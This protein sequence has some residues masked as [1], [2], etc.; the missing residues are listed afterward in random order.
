MYNLFSECLPNG[1]T[2]EG[3]C[4]NDLSAVA[5]KV[6][7]SLSIALVVKGGLAIITFGIKLP[8][9]I[10]IPTLGV[11][12]CFGRIMGIFIQNLH[13][14][15]PELKMFESCNND[16]GCIIPGLYAMVRD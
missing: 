15:S 14:R 8:A 11:G 16:K 2:H 12:A 10:F 4:P 5:G 13:I 7:G 6:I 1:Q 3:L 9:G